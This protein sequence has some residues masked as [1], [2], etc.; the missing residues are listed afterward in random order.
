MCLEGGRVGP[1]ASLA[2]SEIEGRTSPSS[3]TIPPRRPLGPFFE[4]FPRKGGEKR[5]F[6]KPTIS[7]G[8]RE[9]GDII[10]SFLPAV[11]LDQSCS[12]ELPTELSQDL[13]GGK[14]ASSRR[15]AELSQAI[16]Q[17]V[18]SKSPSVSLCE[19]KSQNSMDTGRQ[20]TQET[21]SKVV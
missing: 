17:L 9:P 20:E 1:G 12:P 19:P 7:V 18:V 16:N 3:P 2:K 5:T 21:G 14:M 11:P 10:Q 8:F 6:L 15:R 13:S 4:L